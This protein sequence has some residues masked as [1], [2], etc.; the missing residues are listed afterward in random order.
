MTDKSNWPV[1]GGFPTAN[2]LIDDLQ[3]TMFFVFLKIVIIAL[4]WKSYHKTIKFYDN[5]VFRFF[6]V[7]KKNQTL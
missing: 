6:P 3:K 2:H 5:L 1:K 7:I 4:G